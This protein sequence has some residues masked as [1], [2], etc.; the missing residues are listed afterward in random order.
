[1]LERLSEEVK[2]RLR[3]LTLDLAGPRREALEA[4]AK[5]HNEFGVDPFGFDPD[6]ALSAIAPFAWPYPAAPKP[7]TAPPEVRTW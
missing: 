3:Q 1:M 2:G 5:P 7:R 6:Y 4:L